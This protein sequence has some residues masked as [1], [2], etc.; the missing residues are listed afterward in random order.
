M[1]VLF[2]NAEWR[3]GRK[4]KVVRYL[5]LCNLWQK[6]GWLIANALQLSQWL[7]WQK[8]T[9]HMQAKRKCNVWLWCS[10]AAA[11]YVNS[12]KWVTVSQTNYHLKFVNICEQI[13]KLPIILNFMFENI[14]YAIRQAKTI[15]LFRPC[16]LLSWPTVWEMSRHLS[17]TNTWLSSEC[18]IVSL[19]GH[20][21]DTVMELDKGTLNSSINCCDPLAH[22]TK[23]ASTF[24]SRGKLM[25]SKAALVIRSLAWFILTQKSR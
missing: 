17:P 12:R 14:H 22:A 23:N 1:Q 18:S 5:Q 9:T 21:K 3:E 20:S 10:G 11:H 24:I 6:D 8:C 2:G 7:L 4:D 13:S 16:W 25:Q 15:Q 19:V